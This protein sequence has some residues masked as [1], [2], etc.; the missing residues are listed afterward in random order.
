MVVLPMAPKDGMQISTL[1]GT[2]I[3]RYFGTKKGKAKI[4]IDAPGEVEITRARPPLPIQP[5]GHEIQ[6]GTLP[7]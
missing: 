4:G 5:K 3:V 1:F 7:D 6:L 2:V